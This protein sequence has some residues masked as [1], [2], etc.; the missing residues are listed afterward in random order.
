MEPKCLRRTWND[1]DYLWNIKEVVTVVYLMRMES[2]RHVKKICEFKADG[3]RPRGWHRMDCK[4]NIR[5]ILQYLKNSRGKYHESEVNGKKR[6]LIQ[7]MGK[8]PTL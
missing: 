3:I 6:K 2:R 1:S 5:N 4:D 7:K 8:E